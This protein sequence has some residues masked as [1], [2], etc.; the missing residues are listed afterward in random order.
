MK[1]TKLTKEEF[2]DFLLTQ[3]IDNPNQSLQKA[4]SYDLSGQPYDIYG[5]KDDHGE[6]KIAGLYIYFRALKAFKIARCIRGPIGAVEDMDLVAFYMQSLKEELSKKNVIRLNFVPNIEYTKRDLD[7]NIVEGT[8]RNDKIIKEY[9]KI[10]INHLEFYD[11]YLTDSM[12][13][14]FIKDLSE[15]ESYDD[16]VESFDRRTR[17]TVNQAIRNGVKVRELDRDEIPIAYDLFSQVS[18]RE[19]LTLRDIDFF[20][21]QYDSHKKEGDH[22]KFSAAYINV[23]EYEEILNERLSEISNNKKMY[24]ERIAENP[25]NKKSENLLKQEEI[26]YKAAQRRL[27]LID[28]MNELAVDGKLY[29]AAGMFYINSNVLSYYNGG[30]LHEYLNIGG[31]TFLQAEMMRYAFEQDIEIYDFYGTFG[32]YSG[33][34][35]DD[36]IYE[37]KRGFGGRVVEYIGEFEM[38]IK[39]LQNKIYSLSEKIKNWFNQFF[40][41]A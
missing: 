28:G 25:E 21:N 38:I 11:G 36:S 8:Q 15:Y 14:Y 9:E 32:K 37:F 12:R 4:T 22:I 39:P 33:H 31:G 35:D 23:A 30:S 27:D 34:E 24:R 5:V 26:A 10:G 2:N 29:L 1:F 41:Y 3:K 40:L 17:R 18:E 7:G 19:N 6:I 16:I 13:W 20:Y